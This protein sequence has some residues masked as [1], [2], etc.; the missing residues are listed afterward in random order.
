MLIFLVG[1]HIYIWDTHLHLYTERELEMNLT[2]I[3]YMINIIHA[4]PR[5][6]L[7]PTL[8]IS[9][10]QVFLSD[11][12]WKFAVYYLLLQSLFSPNCYNRNL[13]LRILIYI[14]G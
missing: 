10:L 4:A 11:E 6:D 1:T 5:Y 7:M 14:C 3:C 8:L 2:Q 12:Y 13:L 9:V